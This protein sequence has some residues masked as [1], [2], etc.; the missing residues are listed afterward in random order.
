MR[1][2][3]MGTGG[4]GGYFGARLAASGCDV[5]FIARGAQLAALKLNGLKVSSGGGD[6]HLPL[7][8]HRARYREADRPG[9]HEREK[10][11]KRRQPYRQRPTDCPS[12]AM[13]QRQGCHDPH[14]L[15]LRFL[16]IYP[17]D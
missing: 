3:V 17:T 11:E 4:V 2:A 5:S 1:I 10:P 13:V 6:L 9:D 8:D 14:P 12:P 16:L 15:L 7:A